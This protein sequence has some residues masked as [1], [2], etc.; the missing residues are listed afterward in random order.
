MY[1]CPIKSL[2]HQN[3][4][5]MNFIDK[6][7]KDEIRSYEAVEAWAGQN[8]LSEWQKNSLLRTWE[9]SY[10][11]AE[12]VQEVAKG[13]LSHLVSPEMQPTRHRFA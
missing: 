3:H 2:T 7:K 11:L 5:T 6:A 9:A 10:D 8:G 4:T 1:L 13:P 12:F